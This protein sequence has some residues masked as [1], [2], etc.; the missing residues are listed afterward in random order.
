MKILIM[1]IA[2]CI[3]RIVYV[4]FKAARIRN[5]ITI[6][7]GQ[8]GQPTADTSM[9]AEA[10]QRSGTDLEIKLLAAR[11]GRSAGG[12][13]VFTGSMLAQM[14]HIATSRVVVVERSNIAVNVLN[15]KKKTTIVQIWHAP[16]AIK[17]AGW[18]VTDQPGGLDSRVAKVMCVHRN[19]NYILC[20][21]HAVSGAILETFGADRNGYDESNL[22]YLGLPRIDLITAA[23]HPAEDPGA[24][25]RTRILCQYPVLAG[26]GIDDA[27]SAKA[28]I[29]GGEEKRITIMY[30]PTFRDGRPTE[31]APL[32]GCV[33]FEKFN[34]VLKLH[35]LDGTEI[36][37]DG[38]TSRDASQSRFGV[39]QF[40]VDRTFS[41]NEWFS[42][43]DIV[44]TDYSGLD[45]E[46][47]VAGISTYFYLY[48]LEQYEADRGLNVDLRRERIAEYVF[49][50]AEKLMTRI[51]AQAA[52]ITPY[53]LSLLSAFRGKYAEFPDSGNAARLATFLKSFT[54]K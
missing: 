21:A 50:N 52:G 8:S 15:H 19:Y 14:Y 26:G 3:L 10:L 5:K 46:A 2:V 38:E 1:R 45:I 42:V 35:P 23:A 39:P 20:P 7:S 12:A 54:E 27:P 29:A 22:V 9:L 51:E 49:E 17:K 11:M 53:D 34:F 16:D 47:A 33:D 25:I 36:A 4:P 40:I 48:D 41:V 43:C 28:G 44:I 32:L 13:V 30:A 31:I 6:I 24:E 37:R 18:Q